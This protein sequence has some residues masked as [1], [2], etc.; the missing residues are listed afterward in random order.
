M[1]V[2]PDDVSIP[3]NYTPFLTPPVNDNDDTEDNVNLLKLA[4]QE[5]Y[6][7][8]DLILLTK[9]DIAIP[10]E[11]QELKHHMKNFTGIAGRLLG[12]DS[13]AHNSLTAITAHIEANETSYNY[14]FR[15]E[16]L[17]GGNFLDRVNWSFHHFLGSYTRGDVKD[18][19]TAKLDFTDMLEQIERRRSRDRAP[20]RIATVWLRPLGQPA[21][22]AWP[23]AQKGYDV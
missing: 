12:E 18:I 4:V 10:M 23:S 8:A 7:T 20:L 5:K 3:K 1:L 13:M 6:D 21:L 11:P 14:E 9:M 16:K 15:Q 22:A 19:N 17:F 2:Y